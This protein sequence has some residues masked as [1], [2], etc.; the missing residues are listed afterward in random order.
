MDQRQMIIDALLGGAQRPD[1]NGPVDP[2]VLWNR[3]GANTDEAFGFNA[4]QRA[5][6]LNL[7]PR[8][9][10]SALFQPDLPP[11][12]RVSETFRQLPGFY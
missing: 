12:N 6:G 5:T 1:P 8:V 11:Q 9:G 3:A 10:L 4:L 7:S 2:R